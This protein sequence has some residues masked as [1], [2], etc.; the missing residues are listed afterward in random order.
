[1][2]KIRELLASNIRKYRHARGWSQAK[3]AERADT[4]AHYLG[5]IETMVKYPSPEMVERL[6]A[7][8][9][10][11]S[12]DLFRGDLDPGETVK[13]LRKAVLAD[14]GDAVGRFIGEQ[15]REAGD[16]DRTVPPDGVEGQKDRS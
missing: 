16:E 7:A 1:M 5:M 13:Q 2:T 15:M 11:D 14:V 6:A 10:I 4:S 8:L 12:T 3:L 9:G